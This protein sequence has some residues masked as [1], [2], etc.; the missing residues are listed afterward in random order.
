MGVEYELDSFIASNEEVD[1][2][3]ERLV[4]GDLVKVKTGAK[5]MSYGRNL[6]ASVSANM[7]VVQDLMAENTK[8]KERLTAL[9]LHTGMI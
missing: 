8:L 4:N 5:E 2:E 7:V 9:E 1:V 6:G 3:E